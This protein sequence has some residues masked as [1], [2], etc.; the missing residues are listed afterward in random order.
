M[1]VPN[2]F[3]YFSALKV[4]QV[5]NFKFYPFGSQNLKMPFLGL[6]WAPKRPC[7][8]QNR[9]KKGHLWLQ[10]EKFI[11]YLQNP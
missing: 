2:P 3:L 7:L 10:K 6:F 5:L 8:G 9:P 11:F 1:S 4:D